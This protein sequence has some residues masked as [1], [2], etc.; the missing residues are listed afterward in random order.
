[1]T[2]ATAARLLRPVLPDAPVSDVVARTGGRL[3]AVHEVRLV[4][5]PPLVVKVYAHEWRWKQEKERHVYGLLGEHGRGAVPEVLHCAPDGGP[6]GRPFTVMTC[7]DGVPLSEVSGG[8]DAAALRRLY[9]QVG[10][11]LAA[12]HRVAQEEF[13]Y[14]VVGVVDPE[15]TNAAYMARQFDKKLAEHA[16]LGG[17]P[18]LHD[19]V[20]RAADRGAAAFGRCA[21]PV[22]CHD[23]LHEGNVLVDQVRGRWEVTGFVDVEN[24]VAADPLLD[25]AKTHLYSVRGDAD[26]RAGLLEGYGTLPDDAEERLALYELYHALE[27][28]DWFAS[29]G[30]TGP[31]PGIADDL[32]RLAR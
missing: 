14:V 18:A 12:V 19:A 15:P 6:D 25:L 22:L 27:L 32:W 7:L 5:R 10:A 30:D 23:D 13:G 21:A 29:T 17:D 20:R 3:S 2:P 9:G 11:H 1:V 28:W 24:A 31:L 4:G 8:M 26:K 16:A